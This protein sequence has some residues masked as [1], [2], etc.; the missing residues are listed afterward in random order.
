MNRDIQIVGAMGAAFARDYLV[1]Q[2]NKQP[3][4]KVS[5]HHQQRLINQ[6]EVR[7]AKRNAKRAKHVLRNSQ[8]G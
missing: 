4:K 2:L 8:M 5:D 6:A 7:R 3:K 1:G